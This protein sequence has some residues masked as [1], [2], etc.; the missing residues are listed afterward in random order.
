MPTTWKAAERR[1]QDRSRCPQLAM[2]QLTARNASEPIGVLLVH[3]PIWPSP[4][5]LVV[6]WLVGIAGFGFGR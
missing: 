6:G 4:F 3:V 5:G 2:N 1:Q